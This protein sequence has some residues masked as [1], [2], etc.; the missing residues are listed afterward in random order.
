M[1]W[2]TLLLACCVAGA[3]G[4]HRIGWKT[5]LSTPEVAEAFSPYQ[6]QSQSQYQPAPSTLRTGEAKI[7][8]ET[9]LNETMPAVIEAMKHRD[10]EGYSKGIRQLETLDAEQLEKLLRQVDTDDTLKFQGIFEL[11]SIRKPARAFALI[12]ELLPEDRAFSM[13]HIAVQRWAKVDPRAA[14]KAVRDWSGK[15]EQKGPPARLEEVVLRGWAA[16]DLDGAMAAWSELPEALKGNA[17]DGISRSQTPAAA[18]QRM[19]N[20]LEGQPPGEGRTWAYGSIIQKWVDQASFGEVTAWIDSQAGNFSPDEIAAFERK[21]A[22]IEVQVKP[23]ET[24][25]WLML[26]SDDGRR[27][28]DMEALIHAWSTTHPNAAGEWLRDQELGPQTDAAV[29]RFVMTIRNEDPESAFHW[30]REIRAIEQR[31][32]ITQSVFE[33]WKELDVNGAERFLADGNLSDEE[34]EWIRWRRE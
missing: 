15:T 14:W 18:R 13:R 12:S 27:S 19:L 31:R 11:L 7:D 24:A 28:E 26:R 34:L 22:F 1:K 9:A 5:A 16:K 30:A 3:W 10:M 17:F 6:F 29:N 32:R 33:H 4:G 20:F 8:I 21:A 25:Q 23:H 2:L